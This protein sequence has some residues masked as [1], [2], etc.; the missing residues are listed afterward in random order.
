MYLSAPADRG[1]VQHIALT[2]LEGRPT[3]TDWL[4]TRPGEVRC[5]MMRFWMRGWADAW[6]P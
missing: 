1:R 4:F 3:S 6:L 5:N 2:S